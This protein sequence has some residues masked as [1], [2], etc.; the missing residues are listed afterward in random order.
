MVPQQQPQSNNPQGMTYNDVVRA[1]EQSIAPIQQQNNYLQKQVEKITDVVEKLRD[2]RDSE[3]DALRQ[4]F[5]SRD[6]YEQRITD[7]RELC[8][9]LDKRIAS[10]ET[11]YT[12][13]L[14]RQQQ[15]WQ[16]MTVLLLG[17][18]FTIIM[19]FIKR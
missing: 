17:W 9:V 6:L 4:T 13:M 15:T 19:T 2:T 12:N 18:L 10:L 5:V 8:T 11:M 1:V 14:T 7:I 3:I 16:V